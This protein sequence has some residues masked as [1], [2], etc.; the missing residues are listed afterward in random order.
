MQRVV[1]TSDVYV[2]ECMFPWRPK[3][4]NI[5][6]DIPGLPANSVIGEGADATAAQPPGLPA[7]SASTHSAP[8]VPPPRDG[9]S[10][11][12]VFASAANGAGAAASAAST[13]ILVLFSGDYNR[14]D[15]L[16]AFLRLCGF[17]VTMVDSDAKRGGDSNHDI[18][19]DRFFHALLA[20]IRS[21][22]YYAIF[23]A[24]PCS[25]FS[26]ARHFKSKNGRGGGPPVIRT[27]QHPTGLPDLNPAH[28]REL[29]RANEIIARLCILIGAAHENG[30]EF[31]IEN[32]SDRSD[33]DEPTLY[34]HADHGSLWNFP[35]IKTIQKHAKTRMC[36]FAQCMFGS[37][38]QKYTTLMYSVG[39]APILDGLDKWRCTHSTHP[40]QV[41]GEQDEYGEW[42]SS[43]AAA[44]PPEFNLFVARCFRDARFG[45]E[46][47]KQFDHAPNRNLATTEP[48]AQNMEEWMRDDAVEEVTPTP[49]DAALPRPA[50]GG[51]STRPPTHEGATSYDPTLG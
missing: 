44:Y 21:G 22:Q 13:K 33:K 51:A 16:G 50:A 29:K 32:P 3:G 24:P 18:L 41:G 36:T 10:H 34:L 45:A 27:R 14:P 8:T 4:D 23:A 17:D 19:N 7:A 49:I 39:L 28:T 11:K 42:I 5:I 25:T 46:L 31:I 15:G 9:D 6:G 12:Q 2:A 1:S 35:M 37:P 47:N 20:R 30:T 38:F 43:R 40:K 26:V 48:P